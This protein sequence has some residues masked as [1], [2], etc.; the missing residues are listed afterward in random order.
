MNNIYWLVI[1][2]MVV[3]GCASG[4][5]YNLNTSLSQASSMATSS[6][7]GDRQIK[8]SPPSS[9]KP[10]SPRVR[11]SGYVSY[12]SRT[13]YSPYNPDSQRFFIGYS[14]GLNPDSPDYDINDGI[15]IGYAAQSGELEFRIIGEYSD[16][17]FNTDSAQ[18]LQSPDILAMH[19]DLA[20]VIPLDGIDFTFGGRISISGLYFDYENPLYVDGREFHSDSLF[21]FAVGVPSGILWSADGMS[22]QLLLTPTW[23]MYSDVTSIGFDNDVVANS[24][25]IPVTVAVGFEF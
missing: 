24:F 7:P 23:T 9:Y 18:G 17:S 8:S 25:N 21:G 19:F 6:D 5:R 11:S 13:A 1:A 14:H 16:A 15:Q 22:V 20:R 2:A 4:P 10:S 12:R 3:S